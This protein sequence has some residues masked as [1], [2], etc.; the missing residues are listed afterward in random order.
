[1]HFQRPR[2]LAH[3]CSSRIFELWLL[4]PPS[5][6]SF[7]SIFVHVQKCAPNV[8]T[9]A[10]EVGRLHRYV[11][12]KMRPIVTV[13]ACDLYICLLVTAMSCAKTDEPIEML[14]R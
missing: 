1:M 14:W 6:H 7:L 5:A 3:L 2:L 9:L 8:S 4:I 13:V 12:R 10:E 11:Q